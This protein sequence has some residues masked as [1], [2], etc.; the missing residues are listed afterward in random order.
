MAKKSNWE[1]LKSQDERDTTRY[2]DVYS[3]QQ[4]ERSKIDEKQSPV[5]RIVLVLIA[6]LFTVVITYLVC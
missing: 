1:L 3:D 4:L 2:R 6:A 5:S